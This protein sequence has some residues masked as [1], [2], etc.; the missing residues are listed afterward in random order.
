MPSLPANPKN[1]GMLSQMMVRHRLNPVQVAE[2]LEVASNR[3][4]RPRTVISWLTHR[5]KPS[6]RNCPDWAIRNLKEL[7]GAEGTEG[8]GGGDAGDPGVVSGG[9]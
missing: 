1:Q 2:M 7:L 3:P 6:A 8:C 5:A 4:C 9:V